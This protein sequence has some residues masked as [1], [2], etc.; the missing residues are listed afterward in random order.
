MNRENPINIIQGYS[1]D[2]S[3]DLK[4]CILNIIVSTDGDIPLFFR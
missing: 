1:R 4:Q 3:P 2:H